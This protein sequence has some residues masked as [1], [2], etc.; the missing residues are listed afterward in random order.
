MNMI[1]RTDLPTFDL[2][3][4]RPAI[5]DDRSYQYAA[6]WQSRRVEPGVYPLRIVTIHHREPFTHDGPDQTVGRPYY[7]IGKIPAVVV[8]GH[9]DLGEPGEPAIHH[10]HMYHYEAKEGATYWG[11][12]A[13]EP[14][15]APGHAI[16]FL[17]ERKPSATPAA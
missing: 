1:P 4:E 6:Y 9:A 13:D 3:I 15:N 11:R 17:R 16:G 7:A 12:W 10:V 5:V 8:A 14:A 2:V